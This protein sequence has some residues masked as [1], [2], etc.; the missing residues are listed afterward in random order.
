[1]EFRSKPK[2]MWDTCVGFIRGTSALVLRESKGRALAS[3]EIG[4]CDQEG[5]ALVNIKK[6]NYFKLW[7]NDKSGEILKSTKMSARTRRKLR[8][9]LNK[10][11]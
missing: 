2:N 9:I 1:M 6:N 10:N 4:W 8:E 7:Q 3:K 11:I 5:Q